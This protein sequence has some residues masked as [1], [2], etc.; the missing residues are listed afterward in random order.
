[1]AVTGATTLTGALSADGGITTS[2][3]SSHSS[4]ISTDSATFISNGGGMAL[5]G[6]S[7]GGT[8]LNA[9][10]MSSTGPAEL[11]GDLVISQSPDAAF[12]NGGN[13]QVQKNA[14][15]GGT[16]AVTGATTLNGATT[17]NNSLNVNGAT[18]LVGTTNINTTGTA[19][20]KIGN[21]SAPVA[22]T[23]SSVSMTGGTTN[24]TLNSNGASFS[25]NGAPSKVTGIANGTGDFDAVNVRQ[26]SSAVASV[27]AA[28]NIPGVDTTKT[29]SF[30]VGL[31]SYMNS[32]ALAMGG[33]YRFS[34]NGVVRAS[35]ATGMNSGGSKAVIGV[36]AGW[37]W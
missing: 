7:A 33:S 29:T 37:S 16:L 32:A 25:N 11:W 23:G 34:S 15:V 8:H 18:T 5:I 9:L 3:F 4:D 17:V 24:L 6:A 2:Q 12:T 10:V 31:G 26:F 1:L 19:A 21:S 27:A 20:T 13:L 22:V 30:G 28:A 36:G 35:V 14:S